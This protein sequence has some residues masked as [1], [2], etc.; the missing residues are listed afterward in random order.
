MTDLFDRIQDIYLFH[1]AKAQR[2]KAF[3][4]IADRKSVIER[5]KKKDRWQFRK[6]RFQRAVEDTASNI[7]H[8]ANYLGEKAYET[9]IKATKAAVPL[10]VTGAV[11]LGIYRQ[12]DQPPPTTNPIVQDLYQ[13]EPCTISKEQRV[14]EHQYDTYKK[15]RS[16]VGELAHAKDPNLSLAGL[17][18]LLHS[19]Q[20]ESFVDPNRVTTPEEDLES[21]LDLK[22]IVWG[23]ELK[24]STTENFSNTYQTLQDISTPNE[25]TL[26]FTNKLACAFENRDK[27]EQ[28]YQE[29]F[30]DQI[31]EGAYYLQ[32]AAFN[33]GNVT[34]ITKLKDKLAG[35][36]LKNFVTAERGKYTTTN[37]GPYAS[38]D[39]S[40]ADASTVF[41][42]FPD[43]KDIWV[44]KY[45]DGNRH[46]MSK[47][48][49]EKT[50]KQE[51]IE[52]SST[53]QLIRQTAASYGLNHTEQS[54]LEAI[55][56]I[57]SKNDVDARGYRL[58]PKESKDGVTR[59]VYARDNEGKKILTAV[60]LFQHKYNAI[61][62]KLKD[63]YGIRTIEDLKDPKINTALGIERLLN[64]FPRLLKAE[65]GIDTLEKLYITNKD[66][67]KDEDAPIKLILASY[68]AGA[69]GI[70]NAL[71]DA[72]SK[73]YRS[74][75]NYIPKMPLSW[76]SIRAEM[77]AESRDHMDKV[78]NKF[79][80]I[81]SERNLTSQRMNKIL[82]FQHQYDFKTL[83]AMATPQTKHLNGGQSYLPSCSNVSSV[84]HQYLTT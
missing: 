35:V 16:I 47:L 59:Y 65:I 68:N 61:D 1:K 46:F 4:S 10:A 43:I 51:A 5:L 52:F 14:W 79:N 41:S 36:G 18:F 56:W 29:E 62:Q 81:M 6:I 67:S 15:A 33:T 74:S 23:D 63:K 48:V 28:A 22:K 50:E 64:E 19:T 84:N 55:A 20:D 11:A 82:A 13:P 30:S 45:K 69:R 9:S 31:I 66:G 21:F 7:R 25:G 37:I 57:E 60:G 49:P 73:T 58:I 27:F 3:K 71:R 40:T 53:S 24:T 2:R 77:P 42:T 72:Y 54:L 12:C 75:S 17:A 44:V 32:V 83:L 76:E 26:R 8:D 80:S 34:N 38:D 78:M 70:A 39:L